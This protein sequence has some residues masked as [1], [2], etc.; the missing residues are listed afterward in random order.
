[1][2]LFDK[3]SEIAKNVGDIL[4]EI[5]KNVGDKTSELTK[6]VGDKANDV[7]EMGKL[8]ARISSANTSIEELKARLGDHYWNLYLN[9]ETLDDDAVVFCTTIKEYLDEIDNLKAQLSEIKIKRQEATSVKCAE[10]GDLN[11]LDAHF[12]KSC[13]AKLEEPAPVEAEVCEEA[14]CCKCE[15]EEEHECCCGHHDG[16][17]HECCCGHHDGE[18]HEC[19][20]GHHDGE[21]HECCC[22]HHDGE[23]HE[24]CCG[25]HDGEEH[26]CCCGHHDGEEHE[27]CG[28]CECEEETVVEIASVKICPNCEAENEA[29]HVFCNKCG[30]K[31]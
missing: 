4:P 11:A 17:E 22:G 24:C 5:A 18:E 12:C 2:A 8:N 29:E 30:A 10:C 15:C 9:G 13:G 20:C 1:M 6:T 7:I 23:E 25:H 21:E 19:C 27:C 28:H 16:E 3:L 14:E 26:E 31:L